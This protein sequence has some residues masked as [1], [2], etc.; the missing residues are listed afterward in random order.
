[1][2]SPSPM[3]IGSVCTGIGGLD[4]GLEWAGLGP[5]LWQVESDRYCRRVLARHW[6]HVRRMTHVQAV[7]SAI[8]AGDLPRVNVFVGGFPCQDLSKANPNGAGLDGERS[9]LF[10]WVLDCVDALRPPVVVLENVGRLAGRGLDVVVTELHR[11]GFE[12]G[13]TRLLASDVGAPHRRE[14]L[15]IVA[16]TLRSQPERRRVSGQLDGP[17]P[18]PA[19]TGV[20]RQRHGH[21]AGGRG[22]VADACGHP[23]EGLES[24]GGEKGS[25][26]G[27][28]RTGFRPSESVVGGGLDGVPFR[29][30]MARWP[31]SRGV[32]Q[33]SWE[34]SRTRG[35]LPGDRAALRALGNAVVPHCAYVVGLRVRQLLNSCPAVEAAP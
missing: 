35:R 27:G 16:H 10:W 5:V 4:L 20:Q 25:A 14:R 34:P 15:F 32:A 30:D 29:L 6:P 8:A 26:D 12:V 21:A 2:V 11:R 13:A 17:Q 18:A 23:L 33:H 9:G 28:P 7:P 22:P 24:R 19:R 31:A 3:S 1:M